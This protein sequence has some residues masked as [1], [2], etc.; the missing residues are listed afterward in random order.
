M[1]EEAGKKFYLDTVGCSLYNERMNKCSYDKILK[2]N[3]KRNGGTY[4]TSGYREA[5]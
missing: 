4:D 2:R 5:L 3:V 1:E